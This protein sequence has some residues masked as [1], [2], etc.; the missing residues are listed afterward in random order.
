MRLYFNS[1]CHAASSYILRKGQITEPVRLKGCVGYLYGP[2]ADP[3]SA[4]RG[5]ARGYRLEWHLPQ[6]WRL[7]IS[8]QKLDK[9]S[10][11]R[12]DA[13]CFAKRHINS[14]PKI[15]GK[16]SVAFTNNQTA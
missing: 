5:A 12:R 8:L 1:D 2:H 13:S 11:Y 9:P 4:F 3:N 16:L 6:P 10:F 15:S 7:E 14:A